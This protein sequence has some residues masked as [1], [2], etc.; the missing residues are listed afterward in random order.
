MARK[1]ALIL[2][3]VLLGASVGAGVG[4]GAGL[5]YTTLAE[6][7]G[8]EGESGFVVAYWMLAGIIL[9]VIAGPT[10]LL[11]RSANKT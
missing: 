1:L 6:T 9:G 2:I 5:A 4:L 7:S 10:L 3:G 11:R 8:F